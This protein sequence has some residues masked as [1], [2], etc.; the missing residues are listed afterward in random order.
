MSYTQPGAWTLRT[1]CGVLFRYKWR[2]VVFFVGT[3]SLVVAG[4]TACPRK[5]ESEAKLFVRLGREN[6]SVDPTA[7]TGQIVALNSSRESE[8]NSLVEVLGSRSILEKVLDL[9]GP[10]KPVTSPLDRE[11]A[12]DRLGKDIKVW[13]PRTSTVVSVYCEAGSPQRA[14]KLVSTLIDVYLEEHLTFNRTPG[15]HEFFVEQSAVLKGQLDGAMSEL[16]DAKNEYG[17]ITF[18]GRQEALQKQT[19]E[20]E[21]RILET[22]SMLS[23]SD[24]KISALRK[25]LRELPAPLIRQLV[26]GSP[27]DASAVMRDTL[28]DLQTREQEILSKYTSEHPMAIAV[29]QQVRETEKIFQAEQSSSD[30]A[31]DTLMLEEESNAESLR[32]QSA[33]LANQCA[34]LK[35]EL[36]LL[37]QQ[38]M[39]IGQL[40]RDV[41]RLETSYLS[42]S[43]KLEQTRV[44]QALKA[45]GI[46]NINVIQP[47]SM[48]ADPISPKTGMTLALALFAATVGSLGIVLVS[49]YFNQSL[50][51]G[52]DIARRL[53]LPMLVSIPCLDRRQVVLSGD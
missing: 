46:S 50:A 40:E 13:S 26:G 33:T 30:Q 18:A 1:F 8:I 19:S 42:Y 23:A 22:E 4:L 17:L 9:V 36:A 5:Y 2:A 7:T 53:E 48:I 45:E 52:E 24:A 31:G 49:D 39:R 25:G 12:I 3:M 47:A 34:D 35:E 6:V 15:S 41:K 14:Q 20:V 10:E 32:A 21:T 51:S 16:R 44:D 11:K 28:Y 43:E 37:N 38:E 27:N 29:R